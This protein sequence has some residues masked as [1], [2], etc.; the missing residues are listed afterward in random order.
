[1]DKLVSLCKKRGFIYASAEIHGGLAGSFDYGP[2]GSRLKKNIVDSWWNRFVT[3]NPRVHGLDSCVLLP[4]RVWEAS[5]HLEKFTDPVVDCKSCCS[6][7]RADHVE[8][9]GK[10]PCGKEAA[11]ENCQTPVRDFNLMFDTDVGAVSDSSNKAF[12]RP[13]TAQG[14]YLNFTNVAASTSTK[15]PFGIGQVGKSF[16]NEIK[17]S[18]FVFRTREFEQ[19]ELQWFCRAEEGNKWLEHYTREASS[20]LFDTIGLDKSKVRFR[21]HDTDELAHYSLRT[22]DI[23]YEYPFGWGELWGLSNRGV[24]DLTCHDITY[25]DQVT[26]EKF[27]PTVIEPALGLNRLILAVLS[28][29]MYRN[30][31]K[32]RAVLRLSPEIA[33]YKVAILPLMGKNQDQVSLG[34]KLFHEFAQRGCST[35]FEAGGAR[36]GKRYRRHDEI[37]TPYCITIDFDTME[38]KCVTVRDRDSMEQTR[39]P[40]CDVVEHILGCN[41]IDIFQG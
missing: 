25:V 18:Q 3:Q 39:V 26:K 15:F 9:A 30:P 8:L 7:F 21:E 24:H 19:M 20:W 12:F 22:T 10:C 34:E 16:R 27:T 40:I 28:D 5:G 32:D 36:V 38:D 17:T 13:E 6:R 35:A 1:M 23:E 2:L 31:E 41:K 11:W 14:A 29:A 33:P 4:K 37:G